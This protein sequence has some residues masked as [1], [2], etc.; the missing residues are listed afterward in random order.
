MY[1]LADLRRLKIKFAM[2]PV[3]IFNPLPGYICDP[4]E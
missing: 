3:S 1:L 2:I 4:I